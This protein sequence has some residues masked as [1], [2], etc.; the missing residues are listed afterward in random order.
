MS[1]SVPVDPPPAPADDALAAL[2]ASP[3]FQAQ[4]AALTQQAA[5]QVQALAAALRQLQGQFPPPPVD[6]PAPLAPPD[7]GTVGLA[8]LPEQ[9]PVFLMPFGTGGGDPWLADGAGLAVPPGVE[10]AT[11]SAPAS[12]ALLSETLPA[13]MLPGE[14][15]V[16]DMLAAMPQPAAAPEVHIAAG[17]GITADTTLLWATAYD[18]ER[19]GAEGAAA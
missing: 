11:A 13:D 18:C 1:E 19:A 5:A 2:M 16:S 6:V 14:A 3:E 9:Q 15:I 8:A 17:G 4:M 10:Y 12:K 7:D